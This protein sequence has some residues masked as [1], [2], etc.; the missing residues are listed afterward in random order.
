VSVMK[1]AFAPVQEPVLDQRHW[2]LLH[3]E[4]GRRSTAK[5][6][7]VSKEA[8]TKCLLSHVTI[9]AS[10]PVEAMP[11]DYLIRPEGSHLVNHN[12]DAWSNEVLRLSYP[13]FRGAFNFVEHFQNTK[14]S[15]G[16]IVDAVL[17]KVSL[18]PS[19]DLHTYYVDL[20]VAT[21][22]RHEELVA[23]IRSGEI[24]YLSMGCLTDLITCSFCGASG[25]GSQPACFHLTDFGK[26]RKFRTDQWGVSRRV[27]E[28]CGSPSLP[29][30]GV[31]FIEA[32]WVAVPA[33]PGAARRSTVLDEWDLPEDLK[34]MKA[35][36]LDLSHA[37]SKVASLSTTEACGLLTPSCERPTSRILAELRRLR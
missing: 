18:G 30:G 3:G 17:R 21:D 11:Y 33:F 5:F 19:P 22:F 26:A 16:W 36:S 31:K 13:T 28:L 29:G 2:E 37:H 27:A 4:R 14:A 34:A 25:D 35:A 8:G 20:L 23:K 1:Y 15:K 10:V 32:S 9:M 7:S 12:G 6:A 24:K